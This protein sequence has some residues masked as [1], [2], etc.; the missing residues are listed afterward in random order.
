[1]GNSA[2]ELFDNNQ[3]M[4][5]P[6]VKVNQPKNCH[7]KRYKHYNADKPLVYD[8]VV[9]KSADSNSKYCEYYV[10]TSVG[11]YLKV[12]TYVIKGS[13]LTSLKDVLGTAYEKY[14]K[15]F[16][17]SKIL[18]KLPEIESYAEVDISIQQFVKLIKQTSDVYKY[19]ESCLNSGNIPKYFLGF[20]FKINMP[21]VI[22]NGNNHATYSIVSSFKRGTLGCKYFQRIS[23]GKFVTYNANLAIPDEDIESIHRIIR[24]AT[25]EEIINKINQSNIIKNISGTKFLSDENGL[26]IL[27]D[28][29]HSSKDEINSEFNYARESKFLETIPDNKLYAISNYVPVFNIMNASR[30]YLDY[31]ALKPVTFNEKYFDELVLQKRYKNFLTKYIE[32]ERVTVDIIPDKGKAGIF[33]LS[34]KP[35][36]GKTLTAEAIAEKMKRPLIKLSFGILGSHPIDIERKLDLL[37]KRSSSYGAI[38]LFDEADLI[39]RSRSQCTDIDLNSIVCVFLQKIEYYNGVVFLCT[40]ESDNID[41]AIKSRAILVINYDALTFEGSLKVWKNMLNKIPSDTDNIIS[42][43]KDNLIYIDNGREIRNIINRA[44]VIS[45]NERLTF[46]DIEAAILL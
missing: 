32:K 15:S 37:L 31:F 26:R 13:L 36:T 17:H 35:G 18:E 28:F 42:E 45:D 20:Y 4:E 10:E 29:L 8:K 30:I 39:L 3:K 43:I 24:P 2:S 16:D 6:M 44:Y 12:I 19:Y 14:P 25:D 11:D 34:G 21:V 40:N 33:I 5:F 7:G 22:N 9:I 38:L 27:L 23:N 41:D 46:N 1:M